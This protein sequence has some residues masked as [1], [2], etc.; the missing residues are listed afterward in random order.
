MQNGPTMAAHPTD[1]GILYWDFGVSF[2]NYGTD[3]YKVD[4]TTGQVT[5]THNA[6]HGI[7]AIEFS[8]AS[9]SLLYLG[10]ELV[11]IQ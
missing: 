8:P 7:G 1:S 3:L 5:W 2:G 6:Y 11:Q 9:S 10:L 4:A